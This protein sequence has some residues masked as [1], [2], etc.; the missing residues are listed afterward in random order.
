MLCIPCAFAK[1][2]L[3]VYI[4]KTTQYFINSVIVRRTYLT[5]E[6]CEK[7]IENAI[8]KE[9]QTDGRIR[10]WGYINEKWLRVVTLEDGKTLHNAFYDRGF[11][12]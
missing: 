5:I 6:L 9:I 4:V 11:K 8:K 2:I 12:P 3:L 10:Y 7:V 1:N